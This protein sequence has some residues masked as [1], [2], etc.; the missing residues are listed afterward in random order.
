[1]PRATVGSFMVHRL[2]WKCEHRSNTKR[3]DGFVGA[4]DDCALTHFR[5]SA[6]FVFPLVRV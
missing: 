6:V 4:P 5:S 2:M 1:M 3:L